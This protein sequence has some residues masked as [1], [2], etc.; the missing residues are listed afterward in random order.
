MVYEAPVDSSMPG[1]RNNSGEINYQSIIKDNSNIYNENSIE[2][3]YL[4]LCE[5]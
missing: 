4:I 2:V 3:S 5:L 1:Q